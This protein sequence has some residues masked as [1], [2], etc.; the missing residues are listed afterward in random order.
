[1][2]IKLPVL[3]ERSVAE[4]KAARSNISATYEGKLRTNLDQAGE[5]VSC[6]KGCSHCCH[7]PVFLSLFEGV[8][9]YQWLYENGM[10][11]SALKEQFSKHSS[12]VQDLAPEVWMLSLIPCPLLKDSLCQAYDGRPFACRITFSAGDPEQ[13][14]PHRLGPGMLPKKDLFAMLTVIEME[15]LRRH[16]LRHFRLPL[17]SA[18]LY[19]ELIAR[20]EM[21][22]DD[23]S[24]ALWEAPNA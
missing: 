17:S 16:H 20:G 3:V 5:T 22:L 11:S 12:A 21:D 9:L 19:G 2:K 8:A 24:S 7:H 23:C 13:C 1:M 14:H 15:V 4:V 18:V 10:W 6:R